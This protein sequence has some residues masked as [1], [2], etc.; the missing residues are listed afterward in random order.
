ME[1]VSS[2]FVI[3]DTKKTLSPIKNLMFLSINVPKLVANLIVYYTN[4][5]WIYSK[6]NSKKIRPLSMY[7]YIF[8]PLKFFIPTYS[9]YVL[10]EAAI[11]NPLPA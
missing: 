11:K 9:I 2:F 10:N 3:F 8:V 6:I 7:C 4:Y 1:R 5:Y